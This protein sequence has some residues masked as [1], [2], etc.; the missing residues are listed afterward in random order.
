MPTE[1]YSVK[2]LK[3]YFS[4]LIALSDNIHFRRVMNR[5]DHAIM[6]L[7]DQLRM[8]DPKDAVGIAALQAELT[9]VIKFSDEFRD[10]KKSIFELEK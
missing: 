6:Y 10:A 7:Q 2:E 9:H 8:H 4:D 5:N 1:N 3:Q